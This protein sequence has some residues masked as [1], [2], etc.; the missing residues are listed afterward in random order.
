VHTV[1]YVVKSDSVQDVDEDPWIPVGRP[2][3]DRVLE[4][5]PVPVPVLVWVGPVGVIG[6]E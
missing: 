1:V 4:T 6:A 2:V 5:V 3:V